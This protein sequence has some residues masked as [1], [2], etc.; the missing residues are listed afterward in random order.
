MFLQASN[1]S[2]VL[3]ARN[4]LPAQEMQLL[5]EL[6][7]KLSHVTSSWPLASPEQY[8]TE[9]CSPKEYCASCVWYQLRTEIRHFFTFYRH[10][11]S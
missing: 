11:S 7:N 1:A 9:Q 10:F 2:T 4:S 3:C 5:K 6:P 8:A